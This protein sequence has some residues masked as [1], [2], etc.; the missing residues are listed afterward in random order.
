MSLEPGKL[1]DC[2]MPRTFLFWVGDV[3]S[4]YPLWLWIIPQASTD[5]FNAS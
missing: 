5:D 2:L 3:P 4:L 1:T